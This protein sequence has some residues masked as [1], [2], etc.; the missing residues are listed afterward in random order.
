MNRNRPAPA[1][2][3]ALFQQKYNTSRINLLIVLIATL[4]NGAL[5][6]FGS[7]T[8]FLFSAILPYSLVL[9]AAINT[10]RFSDEFY[11]QIEWPEGTPFEDASVLYIMIAIAAVMLLAYLLCWIFSKKKVGWLIA[12]T[13]FFGLDTLYMVF[14]Y[15]ISADSL[16]D[17]VFHGLVLYYLISG[18]VYGIKLNKLPPEEPV[19]EGTAIEIPVAGEASS[20]FVPTVEP[21]PAEQTAE[22][23]TN[24]N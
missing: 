11:A 8:Y 12:A 17:L 22:S 24:H 6:A 1:N 15:G 21:A 20:V 4:I 5:A 10:G 9:G 16:F 2:E 19:F 14:I 7:T 3:R 18:V 13:V 23:E